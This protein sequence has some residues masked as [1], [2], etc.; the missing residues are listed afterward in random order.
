MHA[1]EKINILKDHGMKVNPA[2]QIINSM[3]MVISPVQSSLPL[4]PKMNN[5]FNHLY[6]KIFITITGLGM[7]SRALLIKKKRHW[8]SRMD[9][10]SP[11]RSLP[12]FTEERIENEDPLILLKDELFHVVCSP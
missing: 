3:T 7:S 9:M 12:E 8:L 5:R 2:C 4:L 1:L 11:S 10:F 6:Q